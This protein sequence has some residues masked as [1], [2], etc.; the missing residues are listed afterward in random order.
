MQPSVARGLTSN[1]CRKGKKLFKSGHDFG[2]VRKKLNF[3]HPV[4]KILP[5]DNSFTI[6]NI[7]LFSPQQETFQWNHECSFGSAMLLKLRGPLT[8]EWFELGDEKGGS[9][10]AC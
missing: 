10:S 5:Y 3:M 6:H 2:N 9:L 4:K 7:T 1:M 8:A